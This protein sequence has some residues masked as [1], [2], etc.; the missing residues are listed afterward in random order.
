MTRLLSSTCRCAITP[1]VAQLA[2]SR[3]QGAGG[4]SGGEGQVR[5]TSA[6]D[7]ALVMVVSR[8]LDVDIVRCVQVRASKCTC[9]SSFP[10]PLLPRPLG[11]RRSGC[12]HPVPAVS[13]AGPG[14]VRGQFDGDAAGKLRRVACC[15]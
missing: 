3:M 5:Q 10:H 14:R 7:I 11:L 8:D 9:C 15:F 1:G 12:S 2:L 13:H 4:G 6:S